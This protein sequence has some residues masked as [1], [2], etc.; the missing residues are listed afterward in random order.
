MTIYTVYF[1][2]SINDFNLIEGGKMRY[3]HKYLFIHTI[4]SQ[5]AHLFALYVNVL[6]VALGYSASRDC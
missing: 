5:N 2:P 4:L 6:G 3:V 1:T